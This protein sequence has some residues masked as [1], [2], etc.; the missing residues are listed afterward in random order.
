M[1]DFL[2][3]DQSATEIK[4]LD[5][6]DHIAL[7]AHNCYQVPAKVH[8]ENVQFVSR[9]IKNNHL[10]MLEH[11]RFLVQ[12]PEMAYSTLLLH[13]NKFYVLCQS[14]DKKQNYL[15]FSFRALFEDK[16]L[17]LSQPLLYERLVASLEK[18]IQA[19][20]PLDVKNDGYPCIDPSSLKDILSED[21]YESLCFYSYQLITDRGVSHEIVRHRECSFAQESTR[22]CNYTKEKFSSTLTFIKPLGYEKMKETYDTC[23]Q[24]ITDSYFAL[25][26][27]GAKPEEARSILPNCLKTSI[28]V[29]CSLKEWKHIFGLRLSPFAHP[30]IRTVMALVRDDMTKKGYL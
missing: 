18:E 12:I 30:D 10:A 4:A 3:I 26:S 9:L 7:I 14:R 29:T 24:T 8:E 23:L 21:D 22:Y 2:L 20:F 27:Q 19:F 25:V 16:R 28:M 13:N 17:A 5:F 15:S 6:F 1:A 11:Y